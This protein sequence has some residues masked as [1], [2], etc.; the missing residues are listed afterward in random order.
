MSSRRGSAPFSVLGVAGAACA[1][2]CAAPILA[3][4]SGASVAGLA[5]VWLVGGAGLLVAGA[6]AVALVLARR[7]RG[8]GTGC[9][10][11]GRETWV[12]VTDRTMS[13]P[14]AL[15]VRSEGRVDRA[16]A[17]MDR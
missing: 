13:G 14:S 5:A 8:H 12:E 1:A 16:H 3:I 11:T 15:T 6:A 9:A 7:R 2:C 10:P 4:L 17:G